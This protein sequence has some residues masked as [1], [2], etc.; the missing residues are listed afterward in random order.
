[1]SLSDLVISY[2]S[3]PGGLGYFLELFQIP[4][5]ITTTLLAMGIRFLIRRLPVIG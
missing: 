5:M 1:L 2:N 3:L 4:M